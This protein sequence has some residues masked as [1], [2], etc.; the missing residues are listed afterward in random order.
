[1]SAALAGPILGAG[2]AGAGGA[3]GAA[4]AG[5]GGPTIA[6]GGGTAAGG[7]G[8]FAKLMAMLS[9]GGGGGSLKKGP[10]G[11]GLAAIDRDL[12]TKPTLFK[13]AQADA[14]AAPF[15]GRSVLPP[16]AV[17]QALGAPSIATSGSRGSLLDK[18]KGED[19]RIRGEKEGGKT[20]QQLIN[21]I[22]QTTA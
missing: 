11:Q 21:E 12:V 14:L 10:I 4:G 6:A 15:G 16:G 17:S 19:E 9:G 22:K 13:L 7:S 1:M 3:V 2:T 20:L 18:Q 5:A 8:M